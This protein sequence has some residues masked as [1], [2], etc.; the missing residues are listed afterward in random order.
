MTRPRAALIAIALL[1]ALAGCGGGDR[2]RVLPVR[3]PLATP[4]VAPGVDVPRP[5]W[6]T[7][8][9]TPVRY[10]A[11]VAAATRQAPAAMTAVYGA[12][13]ARD[14]WSAARSIVTGA[15]PSETPGARLL[16]EVGVS[17]FVQ[18]APEAQ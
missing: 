17:E 13:S 9:P 2:D 15:R 7:P 10:A 11:D 18:P 12:M 6:L 16:L 3:D 4:F 1:L 14:C 5:A 8:T